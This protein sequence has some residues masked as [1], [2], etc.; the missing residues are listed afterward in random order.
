[1][2]ACEADAHSAFALDRLDQ[3]TRSLRT[4]RRLGFVEIVEFDIFETGKQR[5]EARVELFLIRSTDRAH[6]A[7]VKGVAE[8]DNLEPVRIAAVLVIGAHRLD[9]AFDR[10]G[11]RI[12]E[13]HRI[14][15]S[16]I[17]K[18]LRQ[19]LALRAAIEVRDVHQGLRLARDGAGQPRMRMAQ[20]IDGNPC[21]EIE[22]ALAVFADQVTMI[23][24]HRPDIAPAINGHERSDRHGNFLCNSENDKWGTAN[25]KWRPDADRHC[26]ASGFVARN[27]SNPEAGAVGVNPASA[28]G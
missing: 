11:T 26:R 12:G 18:A 3:E 5:Q 14:G 1:M 9:R 17:D 7:P 27:R 23:A 8:G 20:R 28:P 2:N 24:A 21:R 16:E 6:R 4:D 22:V 25:D 15:E 19:M 13:E 10:F